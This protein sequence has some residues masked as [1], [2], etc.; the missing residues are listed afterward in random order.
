MRASERGADWGSWAYANWVAAGGG[1]IEAGF[2][3]VESTGNRRGTYG[4]RNARR[5]SLRALGIAPQEHR[6][7]LAGASS[8]AA[9]R[10]ANPC[11]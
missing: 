7:Q 11:L 5:S 1:M 9:G 8:S 10:S 4:L 2:Q 6:R 3:E